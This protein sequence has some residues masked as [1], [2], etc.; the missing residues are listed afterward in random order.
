MVYRLSSQRNA[1]PAETSSNQSCLVKLWHE[2]QRLNPIRSIRSIRS[3]QQGVRLKEF[4]NETN[5]GSFGF[6]LMPLS[7]FRFLIFHPFW[8]PFRSFFFPAGSENWFP[9][10]LMEVF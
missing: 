2:N 1:F 7:M 10:V 3:T 6:K 5:Y 9:G 4:L 8:P